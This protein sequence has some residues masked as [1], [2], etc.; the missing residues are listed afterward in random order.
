VSSIRAFGARRNRREEISNPGHDKFAYT[1]SVQPPI[2][3]TPVQ[4]VFPAPPLFT[5]A[6]YDQNVLNNRGVSRC[7]DTYQG[8]STGCMQVT[9][10]QKH[11][12]LKTVN[13]AQ[14]ALLTPPPL[15]LE[16]Q[17]LTSSGQSVQ[18]GAQPAPRPPGSAA[19]VK[20]DDSAVAAKLLPVA[21]SMAA[22]RD[23]T[24]VLAMPVA[25]GSS[26][27]S[28]GTTAISR[29]YK[30][31]PVSPQ[32][33]ELAQLGANQVVNLGVT[34][35]PSLSCVVTGGQQGPGRPGRPNPPPQ[36]LHVSA[37]PSKC[38]GMHGPVFACPTTGDAIAVETLG[39]A[40]RSAMALTATIPPYYA[41]RQ[42]V[43]GT[44][45]SHAV[46]QY[47]EALFDKYSDDLAT[48]RT[49]YVNGDPVVVP[50]PRV[51]LSVSGGTAQDFDWDSTL[52]GDP[53]APNI[54]NYGANSQGYAALPNFP[55]AYWLAREGNWQAW[56]T[57]AQQTAGNA[58]LCQ[59]CA[60]NKC[61]SHYWYSAYCMGQGHPGPGVYFSHSQQMQTLQ[62]DPLSDPPWSLAN[63][64]FNYVHATI[65]LDD[66]DQ[67]IQ[68]VDCADPGRPSG[69]SRL[70]LSPE[71]RRRRTAAASREPI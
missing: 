32:E 14:I 60:N 63:H 61:K 35:G 28:T 21:Q 54:Q 5:A 19:M 49:I 29:D 55:E 27:A 44:C 18:A 53:P 51:A 69:E 16:S 12:V 9:Y 23:L 3:A 8:K 1:G 68:S 26:R 48:K 52:T 11:N 59:S 2:L 6:D 10:D 30:A 43:M 7:F 38:L 41:G 37:T 4:K 13:G 45:V 64:W 24:P 70:F 62:D 66:R 42:N 71:V 36:P 25:L 31:V 15:V 65:A 58:E 56:L 33:E 22:K 67:A 34:T 57:S 17:T 46:T 40:N 50:M 47:I 39:T 20:L